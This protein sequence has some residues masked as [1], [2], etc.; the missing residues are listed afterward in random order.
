MSQKNSIR[1]ILSAGHDQSR[2]G[3]QPGGDQPARAGGTDSGHARH[4]AH[5]H[6]RAEHE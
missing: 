6:H 4:A 2:P 3:H 5:R 1:R